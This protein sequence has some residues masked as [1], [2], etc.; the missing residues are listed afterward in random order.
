MSTPVTGVL[1][2]GLGR[3]APFATAI[4]DETAPLKVI[5]MSAP[6][7]EWANRVAEVG[8][9]GLKAR[10]IFADL[11]NGAQHQGNLI[12]D[13]VAAGMMPVVS[14]K[15]GGDIAGAIGGGFDAVAVQAAAYLDSFGVPMAVTIWHEPR[16]DAGMTGD[17][18]VAIQNRLAPKFKGVGQLKVGPI[19]NGFLLTQP[20]QPAGVNEFTSYTSSAL[21][22]LWDWFGIDTYQPGTTT[23]PGTLMPHERLYALLDWLTAQGKPA[24]PIG[25]GEYNGFSSAA[26][27]GMGE[28]LLSITNVWFGCVWNVDE[29]RAGILT[30][31]RLAA[32]QATKADPRAQQ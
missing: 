20:S 14:Y 25:V 19:M 5:G 11:V 30:G 22:D 31:S 2:D 1:I 16:G 26:I 32:Y 4:P 27:A 12:T 17:N 3:E 8:T 21:L 10:R 23:N 7:S 24:M 15:V 13:A 18:F 6:A 29:A 28:A 9:L